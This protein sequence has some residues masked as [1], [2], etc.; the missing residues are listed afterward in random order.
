M[1]FPL[2]ATCLL[3]ALSIRSQDQSHKTITVKYIPD[4]AKEITLDGVLKESFWQEAES[5][6]NFWQYFPVDSV[7][8][9]QQSRIKMLF[10]DEN[11]Y[12]GISVQAAGRNYAIQ[13]LQRD[14]RAGNSDNITLLFDTFND[15]NNAFLFGT[16]PYGVRREGLVSGGGL[17]LSGF[18]ISWDVKWRGESQIYENHYTSE[19]IIPLTSFKFR[20]GETRWRFN[21]YRFDTQSNESS[22][23]ARIPQNQNIY[24]LTFMGEMVFEKPLGRSRTPMALIP[25]VNTGWFSDREADQAESSVKFGGDVKVSIG[26][27]MNLDITANPDFS[28]VEVDDQVTNLTRFEV[29][30]PEKRQFFIDNNDLFAGFGDDRDAN[31]FF[32]RR[33]GIAQDTAGN[34]IENSILG[35]VRL[36]G[37]LNQKL[38]LGFF[39]IQ[40]EADVANEIA[41]N[42]NSMLALQHLVFSRSNIGMFIINR[43]SFGNE[44]FIT[45]ENRYN[46]V[47]GIDY[48]L[49]S[50]D[51]VWSG[52]YYIHKS[53]NE[54]VNDNDWSA[55]ASMRFNSRNW[56]GFTKWV[57]LGENFDSDLGFVRRTDIFKGVGNIERVFW[58]QSGFINNHSFSIIPVYTWRPSAD[59]Q[60]T[61][62]TIR[63]R[64]EARFRNQQQ[65]QIQWTND[66]TYLFDSFDPTGTDGALELPADSEYYYNSLDMQYS[67]DQRRIFAYRV[68]TT[69]GDFFNGERFSVEGSTTLRIQPKAFISMQLNYDRISLPD[70]YP[71][72][73]IWLVAP[74]IELTFSKSLFLSTLVQ[75]SN[76]R[77]NFGV[78]ARL[79]WRFA[80]LS[81]LFLV[82]TDNYYVSRFSPR[83]R[84]INLKLTYWLNI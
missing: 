5:A 49:I 11:L 19:L 4:L 44:D 26:N 30:L 43:Q 61:D 58:P 75:Y 29:S 31:P 82:Y 54:G 10:D 72:A 45:P 57:Y 36:S 41:S 74:K 42:N 78:N 70:P 23:W 50:A 39:S 14:F 34:T 37:K 33:I 35:G 25:Y 27:S 84:T 76:Q 18:T 8:A 62:Y 16:N 65:M 46:R 71:S 47:A 7:Q 12:I 55:G 17:D 83:F 68:Q 38:R 1:R 77:D 48:N 21:S 3:C 22:T 60:N 9:K 69:Y 73:D 56:N 64:W 59:M 51:N 80:P 13:S 63:T 67:S 15:G 32:S 24:G 2:L 6:E 53:F 28:Q 79:Q 66:Y 20:E 52:K 81:D 40:T